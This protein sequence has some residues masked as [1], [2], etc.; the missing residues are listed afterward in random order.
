MLEFISDLMNVG[1][2]GAIS[3]LEYRVEEFWDDNSEKIKCHA[4]IHSA[5][6]AAGAMGVIP[7]GPADTLMI[8]PT[9][10][11]MIVS[12]GAVFNI[13]VSESI[14]KSILSG[15]ALSIAGR[16]VAATALTFVPVV[17]WVIKGG[18]AAAL[19]EAIG[20]AAEAHFRDIKENHSKF[21]GKK[22]GYAEASAECE[23]KLRKQAEK[24]FKIH[25]VKESEMA[26]YLQLIDDLAKTIIELS[27]GENADSHDNTERI[28]ALE[29]LIERL[30]KLEI[31]K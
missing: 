10:I 14:A 26:E 25:E 11:A 7:I 1:W 12:I 31:E 15:L 23:K 29:N 20:W 28:R 13:R 19:T 9:Q 4:I 5:S 16:A 3:N 6:A 21:A 17:G 30:T 8:T 27:T 24:F 22:E 18:T 2:E